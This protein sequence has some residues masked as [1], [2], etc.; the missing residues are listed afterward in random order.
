MAKRAANRSVAAREQRHS[1]S[2]AL[3]FFPTP[4]W[5]ARAL[6]QHVLAPRFQLRD[7]TA[8]EPACGE[9]HMVEILAECFRLTHGSDFHDYGKGYAVGNF[10]T[11]GLGV[12]VARW[13]HPEPVDWI[14]TNPP[15]IE[16][17][18]FFDRAQ[19]ISRVGVAFLLRTA[20]VE[21]EARY[22]QI[23]RHNAPR[24]IAHF[25]ERVPMHAGI[26]DPNGSAPSCYSWFVWYNSPDRITE[27]IWIPPGRE[28]ELTAPSDYERFGAKTDQSRKTRHADDHNADL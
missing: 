13:P 17:S 14:I 1:S 3:D 19:A 9:G 28:R 27:S 11:A 10:L 18:A 21:G 23:F 16:A 8:W 15:Y 7:Q 6:L 4:P 25:A 26:W 2:K 24:L 22:E 20:W 12:D 5:A